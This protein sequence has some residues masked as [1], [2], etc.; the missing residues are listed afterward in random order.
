VAL[1]VTVLLLAVAATIVLALAAEA[2][3]SSRTSASEANNAVAVNLTANA[4]AALTSALQNN[5]YFYL[6]GVFTDSVSG[7]L[8]SENARVCLPTGALVEPGQAWSVSECGTTWAYSSPTT[9]PNASIE[10]TSPSLS[11]PDLVVNIEGTAGGDSSAIQLSYHLVGPE[12]YTL[13]S[14]SNLDL[15]QLSSRASLSGS[16]YSSGEITPP[17][18]S[19]LLSGAQLEAE[20][21]F[22]TTPTDAS[23]RYY[24]QNTTSATPPVEDIRD[25]APEVLTTQSLQSSLQ[26]INS[27]A[28][29]GTTPWWNASNDTVSSLCLSAG[30]SV[31]LNA[32]T[33]LKVPTN[34]TAYLLIFCTTET[35][36]TATPSCPISPVDTVSVYYSVNLINAD[37]SC[38]NAACDFVTQGQADASASPLTNP[39]ILNYWTP[40]DPNLS[41]NP[42]PINLPT[43][44]LIATDQDTYLSSC[45]SGSAASFAVL[46]GTCPDLEDATGTTPG[47]QVDSNITVAVGTPTSPANVYVDGSIHV[48]TGDTFGVVA[49]GSLY[50]PYW[51]HTPGATTETLDGSYVA[52][53]KGVDQGVSAI[54][55]YPSA[56]GSDATNPDDTA[57]NL[58]LVGS[59]A[60]PDLSLTLPFSYFANINLSSSSTLVTTAPPYYTNFNGTWDLAGSV[61]LDPA[62]LVAPAAPGAVA[63]TSGTGSAVVSWTS[64]GSSPGQYFLVTT[65]GS[66]QT[67]MTTSTS[68]TVEGLSPGTAYTFS[69]LTIDPPNAS[70]ASLASNSVTPS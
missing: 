55:S 25:V 45:S 70:L 65:N 54:Q 57:G 46:N 20:Q 60:T 11:N 67:C 1:V 3:T 36:A 14:S 69:V 19:G 27:L 8:Y 29:P 33:T 41:G 23:V 52:L 49:S 63:A 42:T 12:H 26:E 48:T 5:P 43:D 24:A 50:L 66:T 18:N 16:I 21:G 28:C 30:S 59:L 2:I 40:F 4:E 51:A 9:T 35:A 53:G 34:V 22:T 39:G 7:E 64:P 68:C 44:G 62:T 31:R 56:V 37:P 13:W 17:T 15:T 32:T 38:Q 47:M 61:T 10:I 6:S 58:N